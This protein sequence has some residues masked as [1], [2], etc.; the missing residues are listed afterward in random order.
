MAGPP[1]DHDGKVDSDQEVVN[2]ELSLCTGSAPEVSTSKVDRAYRKSS[3][4]VMRKQVIDS[5]LVG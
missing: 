3:T 4:Q 2:K 1:T 5:G